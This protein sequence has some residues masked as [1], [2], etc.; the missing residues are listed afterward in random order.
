MPL[1]KLWNAIRGR[2]AKG[3]PADQGPASEPQ[4]T[5]QTTTSPRGSRLGIFTSGPHAG[6]CKLLKSVSAS[7]ILEI[8]VEDGSRAVAVLET[9]TKNN[10]NVRYLAIDQFEMAAGAVTLKQFHQTLRAK[11]FRPQV[12]PETMERGLIR[13]SHTIGTVDL[14]LIAAPPRDLANAAV[15]AVAFPR[16]S[17]RHHGPLSRRAADMEGARQAGAQRDRRPN[18][19]CNQ[20]LANWG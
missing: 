6:L 4:V 8:S 17:P 15:L 12:I 2:S 18:P 5:T 14:V 20:Q 1:L 7:S 16:D 13:V 3:Q 11:E 10:K 19:T 9:I